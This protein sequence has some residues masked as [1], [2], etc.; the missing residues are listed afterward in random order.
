MGKQVTRTY[1][2]PYPCL[3]PLSTKYM[4]CITILLQFDTGESMNPEKTIG[5]L[6]ATDK[7][8]HIAT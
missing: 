1:I 4:C 5:L 8:Y 3:N 2:N 7:F 6:L